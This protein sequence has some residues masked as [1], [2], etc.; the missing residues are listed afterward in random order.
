MHFSSI[1]KATLYRV[2]FE[3]SM[4]VDAIIKSESDNVM[5]FIQHR[6]HYDLTQKSDNGCINLENILYIN[7]EIGSK[8]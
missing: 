3:Q 2:G 1:N 4:L 8:V 6:S 5:Q 7:L